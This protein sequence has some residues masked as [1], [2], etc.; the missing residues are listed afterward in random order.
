MASGDHAPQDSAA[1]PATP[2]TA[3]P[4]TNQPHP[5]VTGPAK[6]KLVGEHLS[7]GVLR[8]VSLEL[9]RGEI[10]GLQ[11]HSGTGKTTLARVLAGHVRPEKGRVTCDGEPLPEKRFCPVQ[12]IQQHPEK[13][14]DPRWRLRR[15]TQGIEQEVLDRLGVRPEWL[16]RRALEVSGG[17]LQR[18]NIARAFDPRARYVI[19]DEITSMLDGI[20]QAE[21]WRE[22][23]DMVRARGMGMIVISHNEDIL[24]RLSD[25]RLYLHHGILTDEP[26]E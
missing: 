15:V 14:I 22:I 21:V 17:Q 18:F 26:Y 2:G 3:Q 10:L 6:D 1:G 11:G 19:A 5:T 16:D 7:Y 8:D 13:A 24:R 23:V 12:L 20:T 25:R 9:S 4:G